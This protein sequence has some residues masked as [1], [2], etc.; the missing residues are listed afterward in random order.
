MILPETLEQ[1]N[2][3]ASLTVPASLIDEAKPI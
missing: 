3:V 1:P 2:D